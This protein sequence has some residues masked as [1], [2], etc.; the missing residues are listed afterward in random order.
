MSLLR[1]L[2]DIRQEDLGEAGGKAVGLSR[3]A[4]LGVEVPSGFV[5]TDSFFQGVRSRFPLEPDAETLAERIPEE[6]R[7]ELESAL[8]SLGPSPAGFAIRSSCADEDAQQ[9]SFAGIHESYLNV[10]PPEIPRFLFRCWTSAFTARALAYRQRMGLPTETSGIR[11]AVVVQRMLRPFCAGVLFTREP[12]GAGESVLIQA[13]MGTAEKLVQGSVSPATLRVP[14]EGGMIGDE[15]GGEFPLGADQVRELVSLSLRLE[16]AWGC[17]LDLEWAE[18]AGRLYFLQARSI[19]ARAGNEKLEAA[20]GSPGIDDILWT[21][22]NL[23]ELL[24]DLPSP[25]FASLSERIDWV[26]NSRRL[27][28]RVQ[29]GDRVVRFIQGRPYFNL[30]LIARWMGEFGFPVSHFTRALGHDLGSAGFPQAPA[31]PVAAFLRSPGKMLRLI[32]LQATTPRRLRQFTK[33][34]QQEAERLCRVN[35]DALTD[36]GLVNLFRDSSRESTG[37]IFHLQLAFNRVSGILFLV[38]AWIPPKLDREA[39]LGAVLAAGEKSISVRQGM[40]LIRLSLGARADARIVEYLR[41]ARGDFGDFNQALNGTEFLDRFR[42]YLETYGHRGVHESDPAMP[43]YSEDPGFLLKTLATLVSD[44]NLPDPDATRRLQEET[45]RKAWDDL[46]RRLGPLSRALPLRVAL[47]RSL[48]SKLKAAIVQRERTRFE[49]MRVSAALRRFLREAGV[50]LAR[51]G[52]LVEP[53][54]ISLLRIEEIE[55]A[56]LG[57]LA[58]Q[59]AREVLLRRREEQER[60]RTLPMPNLLRESEIPRV[61]QRLPVAAGDAGEFHGMPVGPGRVEG[62]AVVLESPNQL[63]RVAHGDILVTPTLDPSWIP[64]FTVASGLVVEMGGTLS[65]GSIIA[66]EYGLPTIVNIPG[67]TRILKTGD[68]ILLDGSAGILIRLKSS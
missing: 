6:Q 61:S 28:M 36:A 17:P 32:F 13:V 21:R 11:M 18:E 56:L 2:W 53:R 38:D 14:R 65:H 24:P 3:L 31:R 5:A 35:L 45:A 10:S 15:R 46:R 68:Q 27:G 30:S 16:A 26:E 64:L 19:T 51:R 23:R 20:A 47:L 58:A 41:G 54:D 55:A 9:A 63:D 34:A 37:F 25:L 33:H 50:R 8:E 48:V 39:F 60:Q 4:D 52:C 66:R 67:I 49:G 12:G 62:R 40:D 43:V 22:A 44:P 29:S 59:S 7:A 57:K 42:A 1:P